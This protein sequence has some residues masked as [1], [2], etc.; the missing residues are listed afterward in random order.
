MRNSPSKLIRKL[1]RQEPISAFI[2]TAGLVDATL[3]GFG[4]RWT[5]LS[6]GMFLVVVSLFIRWIQLGWIENQK[7]IIKS[8]PRRR[9]YLPPAKDTPTPLPPLKRKREYRTW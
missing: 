4:E 8:N 9:R 3:G 5:L 1:Y 6:L 7:T 2:F